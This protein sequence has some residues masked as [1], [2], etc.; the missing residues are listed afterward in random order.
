MSEVDEPLEELDEPYL[1]HF[2]SSANTGDLNADNTEWVGKTHDETYSAIAESMDELGYAVVTMHPMEFAAREGTAYQNE[3]DQRQIRELGMLIDDIR[4][5][6]F[7]I[8]TISQIDDGYAVAPE[9][10]S[11][12]ILAIISITVAMAVWFSKRMNLCSRVS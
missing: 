4:D 5:A 2:P 12:S 3:V 9:F 10:S 6:G 1:I 11:P 7:R 8:V